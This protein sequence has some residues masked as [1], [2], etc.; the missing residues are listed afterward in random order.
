LLVGRRRL[1]AGGDRPAE[2]LLTDQ[3]EPLLERLQIKRAILG[4]K[5]EQVIKEISNLARDR[6]M[7][8][9]EINGS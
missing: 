6:F 2:E 3:V 1:K 4:L 9:R 7:H 5:G 8:G